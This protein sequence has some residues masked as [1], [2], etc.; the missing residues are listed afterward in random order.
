MLILRQANHQVFQNTFLSSSDHSI[1]SIDF[2]PVSDFL[3]PLTG[4][5]K[6]I[7]DDFNKIARVDPSQDHRICLHSLESSFNKPFKRNFSNKFAF[8][9]VNLYFLGNYYRKQARQFLLPL[10]CIDWIIFDSE[11]LLGINP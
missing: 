5:Q 11:E 7:S 8:S 10:K 2:I 6:S 9:V 1:I 4:S 3:V